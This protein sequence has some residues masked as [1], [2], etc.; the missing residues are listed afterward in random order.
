MLACSEGGV[1]L[2]GLS[3]LGNS[4]DLY[5]GRVEVR[6]EQSVSTFDE[7]CILDGCVTRTVVEVVSL[8]K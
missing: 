3:S 6:S 1:S 5:S 7:T 4:T 2:I 8:A